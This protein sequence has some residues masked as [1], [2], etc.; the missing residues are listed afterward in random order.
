MSY[1]IKVGNAEVVA[2]KEDFPE[3]R[4]DWYV[5]E[6]TLPE[7]PSLPNDEYTGQ[8]NVRSP[9]YSGWSDFCEAV[10][11]YDLFYDRDEGFFANHPGCFGITQE[12]A[13]LVTEAL[14]RYK[15][16]VTRNAA[17]QNREPLPPG[18]DPDDHDGA[19]LYD[20]QY[21]R[22]IWLE[23]W[24]QWAMKNCETPAIANS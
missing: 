2:N 10:G 23:F 3:L 4:A 11:L 17:R 7:A 18:F 12:A 9:S 13:D 24:M 20:P 5:K 6:I 1:T 8:T 19:P 21:A 22:L 15:A 16:T 14:E